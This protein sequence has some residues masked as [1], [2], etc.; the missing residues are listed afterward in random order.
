[1]PKITE[2]RVGTNTNAASLGSA[3]V[4]AFR[5]DGSSRVDLSTVGPMGVN[6]CAKALAYANEILNVENRGILVAQISFGQ[7]DTT[8]GQ[9]YMKVLFQV[10]HLPTPIAVAD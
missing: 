6:S 10:F 8:S 9:T 5:D 1:M 4:R 7:F 2:Y 3:I